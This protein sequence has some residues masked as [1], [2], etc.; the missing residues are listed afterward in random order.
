MWIR[1]QAPWKLSNFSRSGAYQGTH[2]A[3]TVVKE[4]KSMKRILFFVLMGVAI[5]VVAICKGI[6]RLAGPFRKKEIHQ[7]AVV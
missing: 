7:N 2:T 5:A 3:C 4:E 1:Q 6:A